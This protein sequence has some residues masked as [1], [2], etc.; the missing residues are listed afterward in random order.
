MTL[1]NGSSTA[2]LNC[3]Q[4]PRR[5]DVLIQHFNLIIF[6]KTFWVEEENDRTP[7]FLVFNPGDLY[8]LE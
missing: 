8:Y 3:G 5:S 7:S 1:Q 4:E 6:H 2:V